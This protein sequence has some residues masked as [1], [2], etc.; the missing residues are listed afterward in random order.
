MWMK[1]YLQLDGMVYK[2]VPVK[3]PIP[4]DGSPLD[5]GQIDTDKMYTIVTKWDWGNSESPHIYHDPETRKNSISYRTNLARLMEQLINEGKPEKAKKI[6]NLAMQKMP[7]E[8]YGYYTMVEPFAGGYYEVKEKQKARA[9][10]TQLMQK[11]QE[12]LKY[13]NTL[14]AY[15]QNALYSDIVTDIER[16]RGLLQ[17]MKDRGDNEFY[18][19]NKIT[20]NSYNK[21][22]KRFDR[23]N[24]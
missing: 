21:M 13:Y 14:D 18:E 11:Y 12:N 23:D 7:L 4:K 3:T 22:F 20:F 5:M 9:L 8:Y 6:I 19:K 17:V 10:L 15:G 16:Y 24:E 2:L 1:N